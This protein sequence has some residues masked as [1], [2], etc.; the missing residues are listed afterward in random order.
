MIAEDEK[1]ARDSQ[2]LPASGQLS[3]GTHGDGD[4]D[5]HWVAPMLL[6]WLPPAPAG[7]G[8]IKYHPLLIPVYRLHCDTLA[9]TSRLGVG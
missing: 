7:L 4:C 3:W 2:P 1:V 9:M 5:G 8:S 6:C